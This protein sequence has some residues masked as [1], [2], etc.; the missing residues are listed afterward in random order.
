MELTLIL[1]AAIFTLLAIV[2]ATSLLSGS[3]SAEECANPPR[4]SARREAGDASAAGLEPPGPEQ[5]GHSPWQK[6]KAADDRREIVSD[7]WD[8]HENGSLK[9]I[10][11]KA[12]SHHLEMMMSKEEL[13]EEQRVQREQLA[14]IFQLLKDNKDTFGE[15]LEGDMEEQLRLYSI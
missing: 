6:Q 7:H 13:E 10:P 5:N 12:R 4:S 14:A 3:S 8:S 2:V 9:Y 15:V 1:S 11:G